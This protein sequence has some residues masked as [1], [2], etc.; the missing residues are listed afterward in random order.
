MRPAYKLHQRGSQ[1]GHVPHKTWLVPYGPC[2]V[3][4]P[5]ACYMSCLLIGRCSPAYWSVTSDGVWRTHTEYNRQHYN[6]TEAHSALLYHIHRLSSVTQPERLYQF[7]TGLP[8]R[9]DEPLRL[10]RR[11]YLR[12]KR[13]ELMELILRLQSSGMWRY[14]SRSVVRDVS[15]MGNAETS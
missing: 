7:I 3:G 13:S 4:E 12:L 11:E 10:A 5:L 15:A 1:Y 6:E 2:R 9:H 8:L 14:V